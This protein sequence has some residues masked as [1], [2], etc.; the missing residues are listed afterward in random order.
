MLPLCGARNEHK[1]QSSNADAYVCRLGLT[2]SFHIGRKS[3][4]SPNAVA[5][6]YLREQDARAK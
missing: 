4:W 1:T 6:L 3:E 2:K 5:W